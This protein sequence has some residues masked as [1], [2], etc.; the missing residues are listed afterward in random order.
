MSLNRFTLLIK[1]IYAENGTPMP[2]EKV[3]K[4]LFDSVDI[5]RNRFLN[6]REW[7]QTFCPPEVAVIGQYYN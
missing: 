5:D 1:E 4:D 2:A 6:Q 3:I 7:N